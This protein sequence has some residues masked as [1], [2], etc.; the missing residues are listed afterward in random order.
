MDGGRLLSVIIPVYNESGTIKGIVEQVREEKTEKEIIIVDDGSTDGTREILED[1]IREE[2]EKLLFHDENEGK[3]SAIQT[4]LQHMK[5]E[6]VVIQD[7]DL[8]YNPKD[9]SKLL[10]PIEEGKAD[11]VYGSRFLNEKNNQFFGNSQ[12]LANRFLTF[13]SNIFTGFDISD[14]ETCYKVFRK[15]VIEQIEL[16]EN[17]FGIEPEITAKISKLDCEVTEVPVKY[18]ARKQSEGKEIDWKDGIWA[19]WCIMKYSIKS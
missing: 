4:A 17:S 14:M 12:Y 8:E 19:I 6:I 11:V 5:G 9:Y 15:D 10:R 1:E 18:E 2:V 3:G 7:A 13:L 16:Q